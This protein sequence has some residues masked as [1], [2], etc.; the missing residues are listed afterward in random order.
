MTPPDQFDF[1]TPIDRRGTWTEK[2]ARYEGRDVIPLWLADMDFHAPPAVIEALHRR[3]D[4]GVFGYTVVPEELIEAVL[5]MLQ[6]TYRWKVERDWLVWLPSLV[7]GINLACRALTDNGDEILTAVPVYPPFLSAPE[8]AE[9]NLIRA[10]LARESGRWVFDFDRLERAVTPRT[11]LFLL[12]SPHN[13]VGRAYSRE[14]LTRIAR[15]CESHDMK[16]CSD[17]IHCGLVLDP[18]KSHLPTA[19]IDPDI[20]ARTVT[21]MAPTKTFNLPGLGCAFAIIPNPELRKRFRKAKAGIVPSVTALAFTAA[22]AA[23]REGLAWHAALLDYLRGNRDIV[24]QAVNQM[25]GLSMT[26]VEA[27]YI[28]W[29]DA[30][31]SGIEHPMEFFEAAGVAPGNGAE[32]GGPGFLRLIFACPRSTLRM[33]LERMAKALQA[34]TGQEQRG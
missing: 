8:H 9:R 32:F 21:L 12:C 19:S 1:D 2:W 4:H 23:Y 27:T 28:A 25:P 16:I 17:E 15:F 34:H 24:T 3:V 26:H 6:T 33:A 29:I 22:T 10:P 20:A 11:R 14:E 5:S 30:R 13:P 31:A 7:T 18:D